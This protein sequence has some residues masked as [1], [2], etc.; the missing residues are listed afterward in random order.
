[1]CPDKTQ[2]LRLCVSVLGLG[3][4]CYSVGFADRGFRIECLRLS[5]LRIAVLP[6]IRSCKHS[7][8]TS[9]QRT[10]IT[11]CEVLTMPT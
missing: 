10:W 9:L 7:V 4:G 5:D 8:K 3:V 2:D 1:M 11:S 6:L